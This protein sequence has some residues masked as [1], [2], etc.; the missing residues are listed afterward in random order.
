MPQRLLCLPAAYL[1]GALLALALASAPAQATSSCVTVLSLAFDPQSADVAYAGLYGDFSACAGI[2][3]VV[4]SDDGGPSWRP[5]TVGLPPYSWGSRLSFS[6]D[7]RLFAV[8]QSPVPSSPGETV[9]VFVSGDG[10]RSWSRVPVPLSMG[11]L[12]R[13]RRQ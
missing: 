11:R 4:R 6:P 8:L 5:A 10:A 9:G 2:A 12:S 7:G 3:T 1:S 13:S